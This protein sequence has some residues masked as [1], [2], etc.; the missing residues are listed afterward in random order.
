MAM[1]TTEARLEALSRA[2][3]RGFVEVVATVSG[4]YDRAHD[5]V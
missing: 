1:P 5:A 2:R 4:G 3:Y